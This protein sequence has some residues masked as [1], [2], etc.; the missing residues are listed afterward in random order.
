[1][2]KEEGSKY[3][4]GSLPGSVKNDEVWD[5]FARFGTILSV[6]VIRN[7]QT[8]YCKG[9][10]FIRIILGV[11]ERQFL[12][13]KHLFKGS[14]KLT[15]QRHLE[16]RELHK[17]KEEFDSTRLFLT[18]L[19][20]WITED[21]LIA[22]F[23]Q[24]GTVELAFTAFNKNK[25]REQNLGCVHFD[26]TT[27]LDRVIQESPHMI[28]GSRVKCARY[29]GKKIR[30]T[31]D[32]VIEGFKGSGEYN[33]NSYSPKKVSNLR[34]ERPPDYSKSDSCRIEQPAITG[35][36]ALSLVLVQEDHPIA[37]KRIA[38]VLT[39]SH[40]DMKNIRFNIL[41]KTRLQVE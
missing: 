37:T 28:S 39:T 14:R 1:M 20:P 27:I 4:V 11:S 17:K 15:V 30:S 21:D 32:S 25:V 7:Q 13:D 5:H 12:L 23:S 10:G 8:Q 41:P 26:N 38:P 19:M 22:Y 33:Y 35:G 31:S 6:D 40:Q 3:F 24:Y 29:L 18:G 9:F 36:H 16:G 2:Y 34:P